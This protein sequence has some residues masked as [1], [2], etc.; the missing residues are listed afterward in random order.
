[1]TRQVI[2]V[3]NEAVTEDG[4]YSDLLMAWG[5]YIDHDIAFTPQSTSKAAFAGGADCQL[6]CENR[7]P[8]F[9]IQVGSVDTQ[10]G[11]VDTQVGSVDTGGICGHTGRICRRPRFYYGTNRRHRKHSNT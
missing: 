3:S 7:S 8:C 1:M 11:C 10:E 2:H 4:Q 5:Q 6:T 9:P